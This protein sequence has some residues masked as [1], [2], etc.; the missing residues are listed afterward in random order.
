MFIRLSR[1][2]FLWKKLEFFFSVKKNLNL[3]EMSVWPKQCCTI[4]NF[5]NQHFSSLLLWSSAAC[6]L[7]WAWNS[8]CLISYACILLKT[9]G[10][11]S[12]V[13]PCKLFEIMGFLNAAVLLSPL[14]PPLMQ[15]RIGF[16]NPD[17]RVW[18]E[19]TMI[20]NLCKDANK[21]A[22][23]DSPALPQPRDSIIIITMII[24]IEAAQLLIFQLSQCCIKSPI[25]SST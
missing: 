6:H 12:F 2:L 17:K 24:V 20:M 14:F 19:E 9:G 13:P 4:T 11:K 18:A 23:S 15:Q 16:Y 22:L 7:I 5:L 8:C 21:R 3:N 10:K 1:N 25:V